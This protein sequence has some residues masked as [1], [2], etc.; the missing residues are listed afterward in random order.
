[1]TRLID[2][3]ALLSKLYSRFEG[4]SKAE[5]IAHIENA[6][7]VQREATVFFEDDDKEVLCFEQYKPEHIVVVLDYAKGEYVQVLRPNADG[8]TSSKMYEVAPVQREGWVSVPIEPTEEMID[9]AFVFLKDG[10]VENIDGDDIRGAIRYAIQAAQT[11][12][13]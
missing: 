10:G 6:P 7:T 4:L 11:D 1:M 9:A 5:T 3:D 8:T 13:E 2:A 12:T